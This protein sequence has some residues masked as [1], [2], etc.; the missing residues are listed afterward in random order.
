MADV[1]PEI[2]YEVTVSDELRR[3]RELARTGAVVGPRDPEPTARSAPE[4]L[5]PGPRNSRGDVSG[6]EPGTEDPGAATPPVLDTSPDRP[7]GTTKPGPFVD[8]AGS[9]LGMSRRSGPFEAISLRRDGQRPIQFFGANL[10]TLRSGK[11]GKSETTGESQIA[12]YLTDANS[13]IACVAIDP[14]DHWLVG[15]VHRARL[16]LD[17]EDLTRFL[18]S[19]APEET[20][21]GLVVNGRA[22]S[23]R[24]PRGSRGSRGWISHPCRLDRTGKPL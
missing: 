19:S 6:A 20:I 9:S 15:A 10:L 8:D 12:L 5:E 1:L 17:S 7:N 24:S 11:R 23:G 3:L 13:V 22:P 16:V 18:R 21:G 14:P 2:R 4:E